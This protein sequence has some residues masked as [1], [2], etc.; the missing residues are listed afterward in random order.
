MEFGVTER[1]LERL[2][3]EIQDK[4]FYRFAVPELICLHQKFGRN[5]VSFSQSHRFRRICLINELVLETP[6]V[7]WLNYFIEVLN[8]LKTAIETYGITAGMDRKKQM[9][10]ANLFSHM[11]NCLRNRNK[12]VTGDD[13]ALEFE[14]KLKVPKEA[15]LRRLQGP[16]TE[17]E[18]LV[19]GQKHERVCLSI[20]PNR[21]IQ[22]YTDAWQEHRYSF[23]LNSRVEQS[24]FYYDSRTETVYFTELS[25]IYKK[26]LT[27]D[28]D[29]QVVVESPSLGRFFMAVDGHHFHLVCHNSDGLYVM[30]GDLREGRFTRSLLQW[31][32]GCILNIHGIEDTLV[33]QQNDRIAV[34]RS[35]L[36]SPPKLVER[37][38][39]PIAVLNPHCIAF[40]GIDAFGS[41][42]VK[43]LRKTE[44]GVKVSMI[45]KTGDQ[46][47]RY[48][49]QI[50]GVMSGGTL[51]VYLIEDEKVD[52]SLLFEAKPG[53]QPPRGNIYSLYGR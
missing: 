35:N 3:V 53:P 50:L 20:A 25:K 37:G 24:A 48:A 1:F 10:D 32:Q 2:S 31:K 40:N 21:S 34:F 41:S 18:T 19:I 44:N 47:R 17:E 29:R 9:G 8:N 7:S 33:V 39:G 6:E 26:N 30:Y 27:D 42:V 46:I 38:V 28:S 12:M 16:E 36:E 49:N 45:R 43:I 11:H 52:P 4:I 13:K 51:F 23:K 14:I 15:A 22:L 5:F